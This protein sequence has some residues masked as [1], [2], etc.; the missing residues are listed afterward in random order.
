ML[1][2][3]RLLSDIYINYHQ[4]DNEMKI[5]IKYDNH[6]IQYVFTKKY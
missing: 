5:I 6:N 3:K 2:N 4:L 1:D